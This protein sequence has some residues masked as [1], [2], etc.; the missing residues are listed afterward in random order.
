MRQVIDID[1]PVFRDTP[2]LPLR[3]KGQI[4]LNRSRSQ[5]PNTIAKN[6]HVSVLA[7]LI[8]SL[9]SLVDSSNGLRDDQQRDLSEALARFYPQL[10]EP[11]GWPPAL[12]EQDAKTIERQNLLSGAI[13]LG[14][15]D[16]VKII[17]S[18]HPIDLH[19]INPYFGLPLSL[20]VFFG[21]IQIVQ[22]LLDIGCDPGCEYNVFH[23]PR[24]H[25][26]WDAD[27]DPTSFV[28]TLPSPTDSGNPYGSALQA[29]VRR[30]HRD[31]VRLLLQPEY[32][33][34]MAKPEYF[35]SILSAVRG[36]NINLIYL[37][38]E[39]A[40]IDI[41]SKAYSQFANSML[42]EACE[43]GHEDI[44]RMLLDNG[45]NANSGPVYSRWTG[46]TPLELASR[47]GH[48]SV[49]RLLF[50]KG[51]E[52]E[53][54]SFRWAI[55]NVAM[56]GRGEIVHYFLDLGADP[57]T[58]FVCAALYGQTDLLRQLLAR[59]PSGA[60]LYGPRAM[61]RAIKMKSTKSISI[62]VE[63]GVPLNG[64]YHNYHHI[65]FAKQRSSYWVVDFLISIGTKDMECSGESRDRIERY[66]EEKIPGYPVINNV[67]VIKHTRDWVGD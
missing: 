24:Y 32:R 33:P 67:R 55:Q 65:C 44:A 53:I 47:K 2:R 34:S 54:N 37:L 12:P 17:L 21:H 46:P 25:M 56:C 3:L 7:K 22:H 64:K 20:S 60:K 19:N 62:L 51:A 61:Q 52:V 45:A 30:G 31:I 48:F 15:L 63:A 40:K 57:E 6:K 49:I 1:D 11:L 13:V 28:I 50:E 59:Y 27:W 41:S 38:L 29:A 43:C 16:L 26:N 66:R 18:T 14:D 58:A 8:Q 10:I 4:L 35:R 5:S 42:N 39:T 36:G 9:G 23:V